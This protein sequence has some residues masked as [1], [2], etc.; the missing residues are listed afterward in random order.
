MS[1]L[2]ELPDVIKRLASTK[3]QDLYYTEIEEINVN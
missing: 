3:L 2:S 1:M